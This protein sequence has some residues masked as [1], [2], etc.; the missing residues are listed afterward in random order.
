MNSPSPT[1]LENA[2]KRKVAE[3]PAIVSDLNLFEE[4]CQP[5]FSKSSAIKAMKAY[6]SGRDAAPNVLG[7]LIYTQAGRR[8]LQEWIRSGMPA[9]LLYR[10]MLH[11]GGIWRDADHKLH[12]MVEILNGDDRWDFDYRL[13]SES[14]FSD[15]VIPGFMEAI[16]QRA[17][18][19]DQI[20]QLV[21]Q[22]PQR[23]L[24]SLIESF[25]AAFK[26][27]CKQIQEDS[28]ATPVELARAMC[29]RWLP[30]E[31]SIMKMLLHSA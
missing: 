6:L 31:R 16:V 23:V 19:R 7:C 1:P 28:V 20:K 21:A 13:L 3:N 4:L 14:V 2:L 9:S 5:Y 30:P 17:S 8:E 25:P 22:L 18:Q 29:A 26:D 11:D 15:A 27:I 10:A 24:S 12:L